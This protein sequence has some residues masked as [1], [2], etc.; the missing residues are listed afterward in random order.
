MDRKDHQP[1]ADTNNF[2]IDRTEVES[3]FKVVPEPFRDI[4]RRL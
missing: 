3:R 4:V 2:V 1:T